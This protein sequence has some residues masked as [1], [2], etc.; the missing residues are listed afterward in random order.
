MS[1]S[2]NLLLLL[3]IK[4]KD[5]QTKIIKERDGSYAISSS[6]LGVYTVG[7]TL[8]EARKNFNEALKLHLSVF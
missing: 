5:I 6:A 8:E 3:Y 7:E 2:T 4:L 1:S